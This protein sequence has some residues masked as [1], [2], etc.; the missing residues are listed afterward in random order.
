[1]FMVL[2]MTKVIA[3]VH[4]V[5]PASQSVHP[6]LQDS[7][8]CQTHADSQTTVRATS[9]ICVRCGLTIMTNSAVLSY[10]TNITKRLR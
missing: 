9:M 8:V 1:M 7:S 2:I 3:R 4:P 5:H 10:W 6:F